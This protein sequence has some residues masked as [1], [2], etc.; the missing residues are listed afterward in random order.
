MAE[1]RIWS[2]MRHMF[3]RATID[4]KLWRSKITHVLRDTAHKG[5]MYYGQCSFPTSCSPILFIAND[6]IRVSYKC[7][8]GSETLK[9]YEEVNNKHSAYPS[10]MEYEQNWRD[11]KK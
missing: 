1:Q 2:I 6:L 8:W 10:D 4:M 5:E 11:E 3:L 9:S 7:P